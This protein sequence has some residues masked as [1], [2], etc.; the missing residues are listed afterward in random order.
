MDKVV[1]LDRDGTISRDSVDHIK[2]WEE[3]VFLPNAREGI[4][5]L[6]KHGFHIIIITNQSVIARKMMTRAELNRLHKNM[7]HEIKKV[8]GRIDKIY[9]CPH[10]P[11]DGCSCRKP[12]PGLIQQAIRENKIDP[13]K[14]YMVGDRIM[15]IQVGKAVGCATILI[16][17][18]RG[19]AELKEN[20]VQPEYIAQDLMDAAQWIIKD[21]SSK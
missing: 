3:F 20:R 5:L 17:N 18:D 16:A 11:D 9:F 10:H 13:K 1:F 21:F 15:D 7:V 8:G 12:Q 19:I 4:A 6:T 14:A 2:S